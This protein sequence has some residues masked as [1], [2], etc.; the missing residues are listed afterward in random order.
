MR[1][2]RIEVVKRR[3]SKYYANQNPPERM[4]SR[5]KKNCEYKMCKIKHK[6][7]G[8]AL[9]S[10]CA[11]HCTQTLH[12]SFWSESRADSN[13][14]ENLSLSKNVLRYF[15]P[16]HYLLTLLTVNW[17]HHLG[18]CVIAAGS[19]QYLSLP[20]V[21]SSFLFLMCDTSQWAVFSIQ[22]LSNYYFCL[23]FYSFCLPALQLFSKIK[24]YAKN[25]NSQYF[26]EKLACAE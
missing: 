26:D 2:I 12:R 6:V 13:E 17:Q 16:I 1:L 18:L 19:L 3:K 20:S 23:K 8:E 5:R 22:C 25:I 10:L 11:P 24:I 15:S 4:R 9:K 7:V 21:S 14:N